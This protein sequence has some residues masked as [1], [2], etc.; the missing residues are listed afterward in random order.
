MTQKAQPKDL[1]KENNFKKISSVKLVKSLIMQVRR[2]R[3]WAST[4]R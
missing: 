4:T 1:G 2:A 3:T